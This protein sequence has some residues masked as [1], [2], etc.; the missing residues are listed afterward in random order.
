[1]S[2]YEVKLN[3]IEEDLAIDSLEELQLGSIDDDVLL[4]KLVLNAPNLKKIT[5]CVD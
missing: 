4:K 3:H 5:G 2:L 1:M